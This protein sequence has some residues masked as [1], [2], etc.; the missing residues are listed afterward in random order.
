MDG[1]PSL[2]SKSGRQGPLSRLGP[3][4]LALARGP[5][6]VGDGEGRASKDRRLMLGV[7]LSNEGPSGKQEQ[8]EWFSHTHKPGAPTWVADQRGYE[9]RARTYQGKTLKKAQVS[10]TQ[11]RSNCSPQPLLYPPSEVTTGWH[12]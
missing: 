6:V 2:M 3:T 11:P 10:E 9:D 1:V 4:C 7:W 8:G 12:S 5:W